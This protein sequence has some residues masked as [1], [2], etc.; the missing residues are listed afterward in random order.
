MADIVEQDPTGDIMP[1]PQR[2]EPSKPEQAP[3][4][5]PDDKD[6]KD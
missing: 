4:P 1:E 3:E 2:P 6:K 5:A